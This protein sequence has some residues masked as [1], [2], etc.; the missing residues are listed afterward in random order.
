MG[1]AAALH[2]LTFSPCREGTE[3]RRLWKLSLMWSRR[4]RSS[5][6]WWA[7]LSA[8]EGWGARAHT[9]I[10][11]QSGAGKGGGATVLSVSP[12]R[13]FLLWLNWG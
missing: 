11:I 8:C 12:W 2:N 9:H 10:H 5:A 1:R 3:S 4:L 13:S 7:R 6:L